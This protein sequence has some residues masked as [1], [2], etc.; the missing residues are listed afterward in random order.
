MPTPLTLGNTGV[1]V[2][3]NLRFNT[4]VGGPSTGVFVRSPPL[5]RMTN[6]WYYRLADREVGPISFA[7]LRRM[8]L[9]QIID[10]ETPIRDAEATEWTTAGAV[11]ELFFPKRERTNQP[12]LQ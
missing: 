7:G 11:A 3:G 9:E 4:V 5:F 10:T 12:N 6:R 1:I 2:D 8:A